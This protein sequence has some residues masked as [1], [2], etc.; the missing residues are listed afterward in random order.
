MGDVINRTYL[1]LKENKIQVGQLQ[2][3]KLIT[4]VVNNIFREGAKK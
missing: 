4:T 1:N 3:N 2:F